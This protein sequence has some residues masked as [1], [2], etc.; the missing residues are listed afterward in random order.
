[1]LS[2]H[3]PDTVRLTVN[4]SFSVGDQLQIAPRTSGDGVLGNFATAVSVGDEW[5]LDW[6]VVGNPSIRKYYTA[7]KWLDGR[8]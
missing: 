4:M 3:W 7:I 8:T 2:E 6:S 1:M 5:I